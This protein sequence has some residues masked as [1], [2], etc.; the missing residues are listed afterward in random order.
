MSADDLLAAV[1]KGAARLVEVV[2]RLSLARDIP[3]IQD[4]VRRAA[5]QLTGADGATFVLRDGD[6][7]YYADEDAIAPL[8]KGQRFPLA[9]CISGWSMLHRCSVLIPDIYADDRIPHD[10]YRPT[11]VKSLVM[12]PIR[13]LDPIGAIGNYWAQAH[14]PTAEEVALLQALADT[15]AVAME[16]VRVFTELEDRVRARTAELETA[17]RQLAAANRELTAAQNQANQVFAAYARALPGTLLAGKYRL[18]KE[19]GAGGFGVVFRG[20]HLILDIPIAIKVFRPTAGNDSGLGLQRFL[21][22]GAAASRISHP[23]AVRIFD[24]GVSDGIAFLV[25][26][27]LDGCSLAEELLTRGALSLRRC[28]AMA[29][30][31]ASVLAAAHREGIVHR[32]IK[33]ENV[34]LHHAGGR[35]VVKVL[36]FGIAKFLGDTSDTGKACLTRTGEFMGTPSF[37]APERVRGGIDD[38]RSD[39]Y[40]LGAMLYRMVCGALPWDEQRML[41]MMLGDNADVPPPPISSQRPGVPPELENLIRRAL[42]W[43]AAERPTAE[44]MA[45]SLA[46]L[47]ENIGEEEELPVVQP[48][49]M[50]PTLVRVKSPVPVTK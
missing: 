24:S 46:A 1:G 34:F 40:S 3:T 47:A 13:T 9:A 28:A 10:A 2:Q 22:E 38:G 20:R 29:G 45:A 11:F 49:A 5:R 4:I 48:S 17:N 36:D 6:R 43:E 32:D 8:W 39:V 31:V 50:A 42:A 19:I 23:N 12:V 15:T 21:R 14:Q 41:K 25:L 27:L 33:P 37:V 18:D 7:C 35:E 44:E 30:A 16:N 26:E